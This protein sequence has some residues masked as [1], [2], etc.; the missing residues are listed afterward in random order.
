[1]GSAAGIADLSVF[2][3]SESPMTVSLITSDKM[4]GWIDTF[5]D[6]VVDPLVIYSSV[7]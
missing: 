4:H 3:G 7:A 6:I 2:R 1:M 5:N